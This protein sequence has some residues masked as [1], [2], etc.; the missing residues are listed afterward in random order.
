VELATSRL[1]D[2]PPARLV[3]DDR[4]AVEMHRAEVWGVATG[5]IPKSLGVCPTVPRGRAQRAPS[6]HHVCVEVQIDLRTTQEAL[7]RAATKIAALL[8]GVVD[9][10]RPVPGLSWNVAETAAHVVGDVEY[11]TG[12]VTGTRDAY[13]YLDHGDAATPWERGKISNALMLEEIAERDVLSL[14]AMMV[15][16]VD[17]FIAAADQRSADE[18]ILAMNG[19]SMTVPVMTTV[20]LGELLVHGFDLAGALR[21]PWRIDRDDALLVLAGIMAMG[22]ELRRSRVISGSSCRVRDSIPTRSALPLGDR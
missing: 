4:S 9:P 14:A 8:S 11:Y 3:Q 2:R 18:P 5:V 1:G 13:S 19:L 20:L 12:F 16:R 7:R 21:V 17:A 6:G 10:N 22:I 15:P